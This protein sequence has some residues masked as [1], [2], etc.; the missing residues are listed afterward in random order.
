MPITSTLYARTCKIRGNFCAS[1]QRSSPKLASGLFSRKSPSFLT[2]Q[3]LAP[4][5]LRNNFPFFCRRRPRRGLVTSVSSTVIDS[6][7]L[8]PF[9]KST[10]MS[11]GFSF[12]YQSGTVMCVPLTAGRT[13]R[14]VMR[15][16]T[17]THES[18]KFDKIMRRPANHHS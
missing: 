9:G 7:L 1:A 2:N 8:R 3:R 13:Y 16:C 5:I 4:K 15:G 14:K 12:V 6:K 10:A 18:A 11:I 17:R